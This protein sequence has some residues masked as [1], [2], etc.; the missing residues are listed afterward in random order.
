MEA[1]PM[2]E[3]YKMTQ[4]LLPLI[5]EPVSNRQQSL[6]PG[7]I[8]LLKRPNC[9]KLNTMSIF[10]SANARVFSHK[11]RQLL[12]IRVFTNFPIEHQAIPSSRVTEHQPIAFSGIIKH[13]QISSFV[14]SDYQPRPSSGITEHQ[15]K[16]SSGLSE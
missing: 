7:N 8:L 10:H 14:I 5:A 15:P 11:K 4:L 12:P 16:L 9:G 1:Y 2:L 3:L 13:Q 6:A